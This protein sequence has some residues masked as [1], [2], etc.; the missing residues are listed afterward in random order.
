GRRG[1]ASAGEK[2][3]GSAAAIY[4]ISDARWGGSERRPSPIGEPPWGRVPMVT[5]GLEGAF[6][7]SSW[8]AP[9]GRPTNATS[10]E[11]PFPPMTVAADADATVTRME[12]V[13]VRRSPRVRRWRL[14]VPWGAPARL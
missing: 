8:S 4:A 13:E 9:S 7:P 11:P 2:N 6:Q 10:R 1:V 3:D 12:S 14:E 5:C